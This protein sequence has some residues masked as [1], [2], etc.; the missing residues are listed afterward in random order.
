[1]PLEGSATHA[2]IAER[3]SLPLEAVSRLLQHATTLRIF[4]EE[5]QTT[6]GPDGAARV[7]AAV[8]HTSRSAALARTAGLRALVSTVLDD[9][10]PPVLL[11]HEALRRFGR[12]RDELPSAPGESAFALFHSG[13]AWGRYDDT[14]DFIE[15]DGEGERQGWRSRNFAVFMQYIKDIFRLEQVVLES[16]DWAKVGRA[17]VVD[18]SGSSSLF[19]IYP[20]F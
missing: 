8:R 7:V 14:W 19:D 15:Q 4:E 18:V 1:M 20:L 11:L 12:G 17:T 6:T 5:E 9:A 3:V 16:C 13:G 10:G 2:E